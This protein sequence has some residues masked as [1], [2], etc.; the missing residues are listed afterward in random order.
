MWKLSVGPLNSPGYNCHFFKSSKHTFF[1]WIL[2]HPIFP[3]FQCSTLISLLGWLN[4][5][6][7]GSMYWI[8]KYPPSGYGKTPMLVIFGW[9]KSCRKMVRCGRDMVQIWWESPICL[10]PWISS[11]QNGLTF[12]ST[13]NGCRDMT[14]RSWLLRAH[15]WVFV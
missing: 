3:I 10:K 12:I 6:S 15:F 9:K 14:R 7:W 13:R 5:N 11:F 1:S 2:R 4:V 8:H